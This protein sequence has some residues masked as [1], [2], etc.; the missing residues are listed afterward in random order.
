M[1]MIIEANRKTSE[2][3]TNFLSIL[4]S[5]INMNKLVGLRLNAEEVIDECKTFFYAGKE[6][7]ANSLTWAILL[8]AK[9]QEWQNKAREEIIRVCR[10]NENP[11]VENLQELKIVSYIFF[12]CVHGSYFQLSSYKLLFIL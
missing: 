7:S 1:R 12:S 11:A 2:N 3:S 9:H 8:L 5:G 4:T 6:A 10:G